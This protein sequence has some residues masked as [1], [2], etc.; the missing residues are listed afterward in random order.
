MIRYNNDTPM[1]FSKHIMT[2]AV[3]G[4]PITPEFMR[5]VK[6]LKF[7]SIKT[8]EHVFVNILQIHK[9]YL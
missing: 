6:T 1:N 9:M 3:R 2:Y 5:C 8:E 7:Q 4:T